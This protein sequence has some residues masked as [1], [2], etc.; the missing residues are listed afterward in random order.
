MKQSEYKILI[1]QNDVLR[2]NIIE[3]T[4]KLVSKKNMGLAIRLR[5]IL[6][7][8]PIEKPLLHEGRSDTDY[9]R[10]NLS[11]HDISAIKDICMDA[12]VGSLDTNYETTPEASKFG[13]LL[14]IWNNINITPT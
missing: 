7:S 13:D 12:E 4:E 6:A 10:V 5:K 1:S 14:N 9:F 11:C 3:E 2:R 8:K